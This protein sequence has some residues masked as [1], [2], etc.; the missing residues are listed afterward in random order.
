VIV[1][2]ST[3]AERGREPGESRVIDSYDDGRPG[4]RFVLLGAMHGNEPAG[5]QAIASVLGELRARRAPLRGRVVGLLGN[6]AALRARQRYLERD[7]NRGWTRDDVSAL[8]D[9]PAGGLR[10]ED[11]EQRELLLAI[12]PLLASAH[13]PVV[14]LDLHS[15]SGDS[16]PFTCMADVLR[17][18]PIGLALPLPLILG[19]EE[20]LDTTLLGYFCDMGHV[21]LA[22][23]GGRS[24]HP[25]TVTN[26]RAAVWIALVAAEALP[27]AA[28]PELA[29]QRE[30]L[31]LAARGAP[32]VVAITHR[33]EV[34]A[35]DGFAMRPG[36][37]SFAPVKR[38][39]HVADDARGPVLCPEDGLILMPRYQG[40]GGDG[41][42]L[43]RPVSHS[44]CDSRRRC[45]DTGWIVWCRC[46]P[47][48][49]A[50]RRTP[51]ACW[52]TAAW[53]AG[54]S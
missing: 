15:T 6:R 4:P 23:E 39:Q 16:P 12:A 24:D 17:N 31:A 14:F 53:P 10:V 33:H 49:G 47:A 21:A 25:H 32:R 13:E 35:G 5:P 3:T 37:A 45:V 1:G 36:Y 52:S 43:A 44:G 27:A 38:G 26:H 40:L 42:F 20:I 2:V 19:I 48:C 22:V 30:R 34:R 46:C 51:T 29:R 11:H 7:L 41:Y 9:T 54:R 28:V 50:T 18:R 8:F